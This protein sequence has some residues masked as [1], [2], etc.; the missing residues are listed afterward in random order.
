M[1]RL[2]TAIVLLLCA[3]ITLFPPWMYTYSYPETMRNQ[4]PA[5]RAFLF[6]PPPTEG[7]YDS[8]FEGVEIDFKRLLTELLAV[9][10][11]SG[12]A[13]CVKPTGRR[14]RSSGGDA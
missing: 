10:L 11:L 14:E 12:A 4:K 13:Y 1:V 3:L 2:P 7:V 8:R 6:F 9:T 5:G